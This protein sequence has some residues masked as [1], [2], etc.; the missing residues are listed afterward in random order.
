MDELEKNHDAARRSIAVMDVLAR[1]ADLRKALSNRQSR[2]ITLRANRTMAAS[3]SEERLVAYAAECLSQGAPKVRDAEGKAYFVPEVQHHFTKVASL[4]DQHVEKGAGSADRIRELLQRAEEF[5]SFAPEYYGS[6]ETDDNAG[7]AKSLNEP[8]RRQGL[9]GAQQPGVAAFPSDGYKHFSAAAARHFTDSFGNLQQIL[10][11]RVRTR[12]PITAGQERVTIDWLVAGDAGRVARNLDAE[13]KEFGSDPTLDRLDGA[14]LVSERTGSSR[15]RS[16]TQAGFDTGETPAD[17]P[18]SKRLRP[19]QPS[20]QV[21]PE[22]ATP[23]PEGA[24][25][26]MESRSRDRETDFTL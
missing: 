8:A 10:H 21:S 4:I 12:Q 19:A 20:R 22:A 24:Q 6:D 1:Q 2:N 26:G 11:D 18:S 14:K 13:L 7:I 17:V 3:T 23:A 25:R 5:K 15:K 9:S 16:V